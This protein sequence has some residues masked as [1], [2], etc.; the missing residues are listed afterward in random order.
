MIAH[1]L[2]ISELFQD[3]AERIS[4]RERLSGDMAHI[5]HQMRREDKQ[6]VRIAT[7]AVAANQ[8]RDHD[9][10]N[11]LIANRA[12]I[13]STRQLLSSIRE[14]LLTPEEIALFEELTD[15]QL[16]DSQLQESL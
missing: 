10:S 8:L 16:T 11:V 13:Q 3:P 9:I 12:L 15:P 4:H 1:Y 14:T 2:K 7:K 6:F 5:L